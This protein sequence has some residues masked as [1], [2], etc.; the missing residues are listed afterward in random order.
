MNTFTPSILVARH[1]MG[2]GVKIVT[3][4]DIYFRNTLFRPLKLKMFKLFQ[5]FQMN[6][7]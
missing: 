7:N 1:N 5:W 2:E 4:S 6:E 3:L